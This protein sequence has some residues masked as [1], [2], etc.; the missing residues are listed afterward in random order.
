MVCGERDMGRI[1][2]NDLGPFDGHDDPLHERMAQHLSPTDIILRAA[3]TVPENQDP[4]SDKNQVP[5]A[6]RGADAPPR[7]PT[8]E[9]EPAYK[10]SEIYP[11][12]RLPR[13][14]NPNRQAQR[15]LRAR[16][17]VPGPRTLRKA[18][19]GV[20]LLLVPLFAFWLW[21]S[22]R[23]D[24]AG[25][26]LLGQGRDGV[27]ALSQE[28]GLVVDRVTLEG[29]QR[30]TTRDIQ[31]S[32]GVSRGEPIL[33][34]DLDAAKARLEAVPW[35]RS[36]VIERHL[37]DGLLVR[38]SEHRPVA[39]WLTKAGAN[40]V[41]ADGTIIPSVRP[42]AFKHLP[43][44]S[45]A[46]ANVGAAELVELLTLH[47]KLARRVTRARRL[48]RRRWDLLF[49]NGVV[50]RLP[51]TDAKAAWNKF[52]EIERRYEILDR[53]AKSLDMRLHD[54]LVIRAPGFGGRG[55]K[56]RRGRRGKRG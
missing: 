9:A 36:A 51:E 19:N 38:L 5:S 32:F 13:Y 34:V 50:L 31:Q 40:L 15:R 6:A 3:A 48:G 49:D 12:G 55:K 21:D 33:L 4:G 44:V 35:V 43:L 27:A 42:K 45:G 18:G 11:S 41:T 37:P 28:F 10:A 8:V 52:A 25:D 24:R 23:L 14:W 47:P 22:G 20:L 54:R 46:G 2:D 39:R 26:W 29:R 56:T 7:T 16:L 53:G 17:R 30:A 1:E